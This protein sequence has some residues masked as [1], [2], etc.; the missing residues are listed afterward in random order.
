MII[1]TP[2]LSIYPSCRHHGTAFKDLPSPIVAY[3]V[4]NV[5]RFRQKC[6]GEIIRFAVEETC[7]LTAYDSASSMNRAFDG[8]NEL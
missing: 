8:M 2:R 7:I 3:N 4:E 5:N 6:F 1:I